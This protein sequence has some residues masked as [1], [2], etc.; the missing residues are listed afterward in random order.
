VTNVPRDLLS[1]AEAP[2]LARMRWQIERV[3][4]LGEGHGGIDEWS[5]SRPY[6]ALCA[7]SGEL[8]AM[9]AQPWSIVMGG[10][11]RADRSPTKAARVVGALALSLAPAIRSP[12]RARRVLRHAAELMEIACRME[13]HKASPNVHD[14]ILRFGLEP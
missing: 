5:T 9:V 14:R 10:W 1:V 8:L 11:A 2:E 12:E 13:H 6:Q 3:F 7:V 4:K